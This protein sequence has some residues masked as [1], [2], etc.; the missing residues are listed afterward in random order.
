MAWQPHSMTMIDM[1][2]NFNK[3][4]YKIEAIKKTVQA[5][6]GLAN[7][8]VSHE[9]DYILVELTDIDADVKDV[10]ADEFSNY[11]LAQMQELNKKEHGK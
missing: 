2:L 3:K 9:G 11:V 10:I 1:K 7:F 6:N 8:S 4:I 5:Y